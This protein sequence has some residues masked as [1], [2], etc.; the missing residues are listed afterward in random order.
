VAGGIT[1]GFYGDFQR[2][3][4]DT[5]QL[6]GW[7][8]GDWALGDEWTLVGGVAYVR[9]LKSNL[10]PIGGVQWRPTSD[11]RLDFVIPRPRIATRW[12]QD[13]DRDAWLYLQGQFGGG[14]WAVEN[15]GENFLVQ[16]SDLRLSL[17]LEVARTSGQVA[18]L[19][20]GYVFSR[21]ISV[22]RFAVATPSD[23]LFLHGAWTF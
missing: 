2:I 14:A 9:Q 12:F 3:D 22:D 10:L 1:P 11:L 7:L 6:T 4:G 20:F 19:E 18:T 15:G 8:L 16:Y 5:F 21:N 13:A 17:G 23:T